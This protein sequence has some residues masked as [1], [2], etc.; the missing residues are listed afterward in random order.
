MPLKPLGIDVPRRKK[1]G[2]G[3]S[4]IAVIVISSVTAF[5]VC[6][7]VLWILLLKCGWCICKPQSNPHVPIPSQRKLSGAYHVITKKRHFVPLFFS[8]L[9]YF[10]S[11][12][13]FL[14]MFSGCTM[15][16]VK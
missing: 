15:K 7:G 3:G 11:T 1:A 14:T 10:S 13:C 2:N 8:Q 12:T 5:A 4:K 9:F 16:K 6:L